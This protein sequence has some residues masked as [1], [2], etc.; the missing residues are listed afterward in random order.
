MNSTTLFSFTHFSIISCA[1]YF[2]I[3]APAPAP[4]PLLNRKNAMGV[5]R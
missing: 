3:Y 2:V 5:M 4:S 1:F